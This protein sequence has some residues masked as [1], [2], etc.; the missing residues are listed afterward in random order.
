[1][2]RVTVV[3]PCFN[4]GRL[5]LE[6]IESALS[7]TY[8]DL[9]V[10]VVDDGSTDSETLAVLDELC[11]TPRISL[12]RQVNSGLSAARNAGIAAATGV[13]ILP[14]DAD[15]LIEPTY[16]A[17]AVEILEANPDVG[18]VYSRADL[19][20]DQSGPWSLPEFSWSRVLV[21][22][23]VFCSSLYRRQDW[24]MTGGYDESMRFGRED[25]DFVLRILSLGRQVF[26][27]DEVLFHYRRHGATMNDSF[28]ESRAKLI[29]ASAKLFRNN[30]K[31]Y[32]DHAEDL[33]QFIFDQHDQIMDLKYRY[34]SLESVRTKFPRLVS[35]AKAFRGR[36]G[37][38]RRRWRLKFWR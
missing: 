37:L 25:H 6:S 9:E 18:L 12:V 31:L 35:A 13:Y 38:I 27:L 19:F 7:Q 33:F 32:V 10:V 2:N 16:V 5:L 28:G 3:I 21:H 22:N 24:E 30:T 14:L 1:M 36:I 4:G 23:M 29:E 34:Q 17:K 11:G 8:D 20:G 26:R 15:D